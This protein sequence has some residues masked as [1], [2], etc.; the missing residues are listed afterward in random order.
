MPER[1]GIGNKAVFDLL[2]TPGRSIILMR[3]IMGAPRSIVLDRE[4]ST[5]PLVKE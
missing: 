3:E 5:L 1:P 2:K 4:K